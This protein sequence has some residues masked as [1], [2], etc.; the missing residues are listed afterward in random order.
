MGIQKLEKAVTDNI[1]KKFVFEWKER[2]LAGA[3]EGC[4]VKERFKN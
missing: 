2:E 3:G 4:G 1:F